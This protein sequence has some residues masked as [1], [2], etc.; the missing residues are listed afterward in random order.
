MARHT[1]ITSD[2]CVYRV[3]RRT[4]WALYPFFTHPMCA[5]V[6]SYCVG[7]HSVR[8]ASNVKYFWCERTIELNYV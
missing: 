6:A 3:A 8:C 1:K 4:E 7:T 5:N 2:A